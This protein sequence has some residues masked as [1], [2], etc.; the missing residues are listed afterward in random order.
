M[1]NLSLGGHVL[2]IHANLLGTSR[3]HIGD[4]A[5]LLTSRHG[6]FTNLIDLE[7]EEKSKRELSIC[8]NLQEKPYLARVR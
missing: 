1:S 2:I 7:K 8:N 6:D 5:L 3:N 4:E